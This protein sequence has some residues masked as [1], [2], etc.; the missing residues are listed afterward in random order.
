MFFKKDTRIPSVEHV[1]GT[2]GIGVVVCKRH[3]QTDCRPGSGPAM[4]NTARYNC[5][6]HVRMTIH[7]RQDTPLRRCCGGNASC[8]VQTNGGRTSWCLQ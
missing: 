4:V 1:P 3:H 8:S 2:I 6:C 5:W 7:F